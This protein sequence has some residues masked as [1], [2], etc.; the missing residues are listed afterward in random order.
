MHRFL[1]L[2]FCLT[3]SAPIAVSAQT[4]VV[5]PKVM[6]FSVQP[7]DSF[8]ETIKITNLTER[9]I[10]IYPT[11]NEIST[12]SEGDLLEYVPAAM[13]DRTSDI[14]SWI[15]V[16]RGRVVLGPRESVKLK[17]DFKVHFD[18]VPGQYYAFLGLAESNK[19]DTAEE[20]V[21]AGVAP[22]VVIRLDVASAIREEAQLLQFNTNRFVFDDESRAVSVTVKNTGDTALAPQGEVILYDVRGNEVEALLLNTQNIELPPQAEHTFDLAVPSDL[23]FGRHKAFLQM[24]FG[25]NLTAS[26][27]DTNFFTVIPV[28]W[29]VVIFSLLIFLTG[30]LAWWYHR[31]VARVESGNMS[32]DGDVLVTVRPENNR[33]E[34][35]HDINL[36]S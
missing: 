22:G 17:V 29:L 31:S 5:S 13:T 10:S 12:D 19:R 26:V 2:L 4:H 11:V 6:E 14:T 30:L 9:R 20:K 23:N 15:E 3:L 16:Q 27:Y 24:S 34:Q 1:F 18:A 35:E 25:S 32:D 36:K 33:T 21:A 28:V 7:R 8:Q